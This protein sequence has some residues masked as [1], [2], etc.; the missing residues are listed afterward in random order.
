[1]LVVG[2]IDFHPIVYIITVY[3]ENFY[4]KT[5]TSYTN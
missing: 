4:K 2:L 3:I 5:M 1:M